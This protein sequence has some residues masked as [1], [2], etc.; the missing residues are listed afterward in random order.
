[1]LPTQLACRTMRYVSLLFVCLLTWVVAMIAPN[2][3]ARAADMAMKASPPA[4][5]P[6]PYNW[7]GLNIGGTAGYGFGQSQHCDIA[8]FCTDRFDVD[9]FAG[10]G[11]LG[12]NWQ[13]NNWVAGLESDFSG[14]TLHGTTPST[15]AFGCGL[16]T[17]VTTSVRHRPRPRFRHAS[18]LF[19]TAMLDRPAP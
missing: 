17:T 5:A 11:T 9:G 13:M 15:L 16:P 4:A 18:C 6:A 10:G 14:A 19:K 7:T 3:S 12:Y 2:G 8:P 1:M